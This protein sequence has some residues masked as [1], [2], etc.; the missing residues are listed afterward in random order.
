M[1]FVPIDMDNGGGDKGN[2]HHMRQKD[3]ILRIKKI[4]ENKAHEN[5]ISSPINDGRLRDVLGSLPAR[6][7]SSN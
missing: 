3:T 2:N 5:K 7:R 1:S 4:E 6:C